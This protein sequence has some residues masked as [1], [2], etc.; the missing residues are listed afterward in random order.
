MLECPQEQL[1]QVDLDVVIPTAPTDSG[2]AGG[3]AD[4]LPH[5]GITD[6]GNADGEPDVTV[7]TIPIDN[8]HVDDVSKLDALED[9]C[10]ADTD[11]LQVDNEVQ[12]TAN[13]YYDG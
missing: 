13:G 12:L 9:V 3:D 1:E 7:P 2:N 4:M 8:G 6:S 10:T 5:K 11:V